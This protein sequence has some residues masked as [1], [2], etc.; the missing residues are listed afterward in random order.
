MNYDSRGAGGIEVLHAI[1]AFFI[2]AM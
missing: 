2:S 1:A